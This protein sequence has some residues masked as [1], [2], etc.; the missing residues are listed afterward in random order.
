V[1]AMVIAGSLSGVIMRRAANRARRTE[2]V[3]QHGFDIIDGDGA[4]F[5]LKQLARTKIA[6]QAVAVAGLRHALGLRRQR[7]EVIGVRQQPAFRIHRIDIVRRGLEINRADVLDLLA[8]PFSDAANHVHDRGVYGLDLRGKRAHPL[9]HLFQR[10]SGMMAKYARHA[11][12][13]PCAATARLYSS[14]RNAPLVARS[15]E[16]S[17]R[18]RLR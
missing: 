15:R 3:A 8:W 5:R 13:H 11:R 16:A 14:A 2:F 12:I 18:L 17:S 10:Q 9:L 4:D 7:L 1:E 6:V